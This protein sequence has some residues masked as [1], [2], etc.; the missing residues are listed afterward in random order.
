MYITHVGIYEFQLF[1][2]YGLRN[3]R[4]ESFA[5][6]SSFVGHL[7]FSTLTKTWRKYLSRMQIKWRLLQWWRI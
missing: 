7:S 3:L 2:F 4:T 6:F 5:N 1:G